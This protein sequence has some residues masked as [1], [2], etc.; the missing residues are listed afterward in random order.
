MNISDQLAKLDR[1]V[2][3]QLESIEH[4]PEATP[5]Q[6]LDT[7]VE[8]LFKFLDQ[9]RVLRDMLE[10]PSVVSIGEQVVAA[11]LAPTSQQ[12][13]VFEKQADQLATAA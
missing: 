6:H 1:R 11:S 3:F 12:S 7:Q 5:P 2:A 10:A 8:M 13:D 4:C 9:R